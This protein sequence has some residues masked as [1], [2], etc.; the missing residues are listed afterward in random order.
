MG[1]Q[2]IKNIARPVRAFLTRPSGG[3]RS[4]SIPLIHRR[5]ETHLARRYHQICNAALLAITQTE[6]LSGIEYASMASLDDAPGLTL[7]GLAGRMG[8]DNAE[9]A[10]ILSRLCDKGLVGRT[11]DPVNP[12]VMVFRLTEVGL[13]I[14]VRLRPMIAAATDRIVAPLSDQERSTL[15]DLLSRIVQ[16]MN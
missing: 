13:G 11:V 8:L 10:E 14:R 16:A 7:E 9:A 1:P 6:G 5:V 2:T 3:L 12:D 15:R 4:H